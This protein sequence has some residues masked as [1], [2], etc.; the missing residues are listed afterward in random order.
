MEKYAVNITDNALAD[1]QE[2]YNYIA[3]D[4]LAPETARGQYIRTDEVYG[5]EKKNYS[6]SNSNRCNT[7]YS[8]S[9]LLFYC[10]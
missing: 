3:R 7:C 9:C 10:S 5:K 8:G 6:Y 1:M 4:L 2:I